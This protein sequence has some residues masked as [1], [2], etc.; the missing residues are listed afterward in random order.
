MGKASLESP[1]WSESKTNYVSR[2]SQ[3]N[4]SGSESTVGCL[5]NKAEV[6]C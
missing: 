1:R 5:E 3:E 6:G 2:R 4:R